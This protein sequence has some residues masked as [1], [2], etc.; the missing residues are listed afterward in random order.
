MKVVPIQKKSVSDSVYEQLRDQIVE[1]SVAPG[2]TLPAERVLCEMLSVNRGAVREALK[3][4]EQARLVSIQHGGGTTVLDYREHAGLDLLVELLLRPDG[5][6]D[7]GVFR[8]MLEM[9][10]A[11]GRDIARLAAERDGAACAAQLALVIERMDAADG[12]LAALQVL[13]MEYWE[14]MVRASGNVAYRLAFNTLRQSYDRYRHLFTSVMAAEIT[15]RARFAQLRE[16]IAVGDG[17]AAR[18]IA[19]GLIELGAASIR[20]VLAA[21]EASQSPGA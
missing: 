8:S 7:T 20:E 18:D 10:A 6:I 5:S 1:G 21:L 16:A 11:I 3:R 15:D 4:L 19:D 12:D 9:R 14:E 2:E 17:E 13:S